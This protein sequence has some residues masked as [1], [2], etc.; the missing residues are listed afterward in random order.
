MSEEKKFVNGLFV[1]KPHEKAPDF[2]KMAISIKREDLIGFLEQEK[3][4]WV[5]IDVKESRGGKLY[6]E[7][8]TYQSEQNSQPQTQQ[9]PQQQTV[10]IE[11]VKIENVPF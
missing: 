11:E 2:V 4:E 7:V 5:N 1:K 9:P 8:N 6:A 10:A 3:G